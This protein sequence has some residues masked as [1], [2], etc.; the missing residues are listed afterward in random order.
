MGLWS[1][2]SIAGLRTVNLAA[3]SQPVPTRHVHG[4][5]DPSHTFRVGSTTQQEVVRMSTSRKTMAALLAV[6][7][8][9]MS[10]APAFAVP[11]FGP[12]AGQGQG[13]NE[14]GENAGT[15]CHP[16]GQNADSRECK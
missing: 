13:N 2:P 16:P 4:D 15:K 12:G 3:I 14:P 11:S 5:V 1:Y 7:A 10:A 8:L 9:S 6:G